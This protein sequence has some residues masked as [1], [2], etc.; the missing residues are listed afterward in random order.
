MT[1]DDRPAAAAAPGSDRDDPTAATRADTDLPQPESPRTRRDS[2]MT[3]LELV[4][5]VILSVTAVLTAWSGFQA[6]KWS[7]EMAISFSRASSARIE[8][9]RYSGEAAALR[10]FDLTIFAT[11]VE[12]VGGGDDEVADFVRT[13]FTD[14][15]AVAF[16]EWVL[17][18]PLRTPGAPRS[19]FALDAY[20]VPGEA[21]SAEADDR[22]DAL[23]QTALENNRRGDNYTLLTVLFALVLF[24]A[25][26]SGRLDS[27][28]LAWGV[29][30]GAVVLLGVGIG[31]L[32][33]FP[34]II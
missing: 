1:A 24:F 16:D 11:Y 20:V 23:F 26:V 7:G 12:A 5:V 28:R 8:A 6:S 31:F 34:K 10:Q 21:D 14:H 3:R 4:A 2:S 29:L 22:A 25:A 32:I 17:T 27:T 18:D 30:V 19:P 13:R 15:F 33:G 9:A